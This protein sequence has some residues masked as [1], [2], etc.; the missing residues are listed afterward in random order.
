IVLSGG[1]SGAVMV[2]GQLDASG[3]RGGQGGTIKVLGDLVG[4]TGPAKLDA[5]GGAGG[6]T[7][8]VGGNW[9]GKGPES[10]ASNT[11]VGSG[12]VLEANASRHGDGGKVVVWSDGNTN[13]Y[14]QANARGG[15]D[16]GDGGR[17]EVSGKGTLDFQGGADLSAARGKTARLLVD[18]SEE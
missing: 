6:G 10:N 13:Y 17:I 15:A 12:V 2:D 18:R 3:G 16:G 4:V 11:Y 7:I 14:G 5:S 9:Q 1:A 8:L